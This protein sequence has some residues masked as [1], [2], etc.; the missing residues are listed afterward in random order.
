MCPHLWGEEICCDQRLTENLRHQDRS[1]TCRRGRN[2]AK[3][4]E[5]ND[6]RSVVL[7]GFC[8]RPVRI[9]RS[10][11]T[12]AP[13]FETKVPSYRCSPNGICCNSPAVSIAR[14][15]YLHNVARHSAVSLAAQLRCAFHATCFGSVVV[16]WPPAFNC[17]GPGAL[18]GHF[19][20]D[21]W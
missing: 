10:F 17:G 11:G 15:H 16:P 2:S 21:L 4:M 12:R 6:V 8:I 13:L 9:A 20:W 18:A 3:C 14:R 7:N 1:L 19:M 5:F